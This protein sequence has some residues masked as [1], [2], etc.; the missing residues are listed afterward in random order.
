[1]GAGSAERKELVSIDSYL[2]KGQLREHQ[3]R[4]L[5]ICDGLMLK[6][7]N[8]QPVC[9]QP[10]LKGIT[11]IDAKKKKKKNYMNKK[12]NCDA[13]RTLGI[14]A[15]DMLAVLEVCVTPCTKDSNRLCC[16]VPETIASLFPCCRVLHCCP[17]GC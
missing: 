11:G 12:I 8:K 14:F 7:K 5:N 9:G 3:T 15:R 2:G 17:L 13:T 6:L 4:L 10:Y 1:M 16:N